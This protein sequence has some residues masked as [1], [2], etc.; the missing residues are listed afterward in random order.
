MP[1]RALRRRV[2][3]TVPLLALGPLLGIVLT[4]GQDPAP[5]DSIHAPQRVTSFE[6][7]NQEAVLKCDAGVLIIK[8]YADNIIQIRY[9]PGP[10][11]T[12]LP[13]WGFSASPS[14]PKYRVDATVG[15][16]RLSTAQLTASVD[17]KTAQITFLDQKQNVLLSSRRYHLKDARV[18]GEDTFNVH[19]EF[20][21][22][23]DEAYYGLGQHGNGWMDHRGETVRLWHD[24]QPA[25]GEAVAVP[26]LVTNRK[27]GLVFDNPSKTTVTP[28]K[29]GVTT[30]DAEVGDA[31]SYFVIYGNTTDDIYKGYRFLTGVTPLPPKS[32]L[33]YIQAKL[34]SKTQDEL[35]QVARKYREK[36]YPADMLAINLGEMGIDDKQWS[37]PRSMNA[38][39]DRL[40]FK[41]MISCWP[42]I[43][44]G[45]SQFD[46]LEAMGCLGNDKDGKP[47]QDTRSAL[48]DTTKPS[49]ASWFWNN[50]QENYAAKGFT[51]WWLDG[52]QSDLIP[53]ALVFNAGMGARILNLFPLMQAKA[54]YEGHRHDAKERCLILSRGA[55]LGAQQYGTTFG[56]SDT[57]PQWEALKRQIPAG[58]NMTASGLAYWS[59]AVGGGYPPLASSGS[60]ARDE[61]SELYIRWFEYGAFCPTFRAHGSIPENEVWSFGEGVER[62]LAKYLRLRYRLLPYIYSLAH[63]VTETGAPFMRA[64]FMDFPQDPEVRNL[65]DEYMF[66]PAFLVAPMVEKGRAG[67][68]VYLPKG[69]AW[70]D[71][72]TGRKFA[73]GQRLFADAPLDLLPL[74]VRAGS[75]IPHGNDIP[76]TRAEQK[77]LELWV[78]AGA[79]AQFDLYQ[80]DGLTYEYEKGK[81][82]LAQIRWNET[83][84]KLTIGGDDRKLFSR[85]QDKWLK[86]VR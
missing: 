73:G 44:L 75:I 52:N 36:G 26:F 22:P 71:Y 69:S 54:V 81:Y 27:Y 24:Y 82:S 61:Y 10:E 46:T 66:G 72:W 5:S 47:A 77:E 30:W 35:L 78:Y 34:G 74:F 58:L 86:V 17:R 55:Y 59:S 6:H 16:L 68:E 70:Y 42:R 83:T 56:S 12:A 37:D 41:L 31:L 40:G 45:S 50:I 79:D 33:G 8:P 19:A 4:A 38:E 3:S 32:A 60:S 13:L 63:S 48:I 49:C 15:S 1:I 7:I 11:K 65:K 57:S 21:A 25:E 85:P 84:Q 9:F 43:Q 18:S 64:L 2:S 53:S 28:G 23:D 14:N 80:D 67:R 20:V 76:N 51:S 62:I 39:L 29:T